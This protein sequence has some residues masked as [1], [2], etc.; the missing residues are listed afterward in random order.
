MG[1]DQSQ[2]SAWQTHIQNRFVV[3]IGGGV[4]EKL[5][6]NRKHL[7][8]LWNFEDDKKNSLNYFFLKGA[9][10]DFDGNII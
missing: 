2:R 3:V 5:S 9:R 8:S 7:Y 10:T 6:L 1:L 4:S